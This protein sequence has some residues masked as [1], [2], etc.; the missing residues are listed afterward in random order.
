M[1]QIPAC[2]TQMH[3]LQIDPLPGATSARLQP[4]GMTAQ[5]WLARKVRE[6]ATASTADVEQSS[7][8][9]T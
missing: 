1:A 5:L 4:L 2:L 7:K 6:A 8:S 3:A 9:D